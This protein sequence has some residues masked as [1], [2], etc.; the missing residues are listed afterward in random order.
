M[1]F[2]MTTTKAYRIGNLTL[3]DH[4]ESVQTLWGSFD[5]VKPEGR[6][7]RLEGLYASPSLKGLV[8]WVKGM[9]LVAARDE[10]ANLESSEITVANSETVFLYHV[11]TY[12]AV[13]GGRKTAADYWN[14]GIALSDWD[15]VSADRS[16]DADAWEILLPVE[17]I[18]SAHK[19]SNA[20]ILNQT[21]D[22]SAKLE[23]S[24][25]IQERKRFMM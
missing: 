9:H 22:E 15:T 3:A 5:E 18:K 17:T 8:R 23:L 25:M 4:A 11:P 13:L 14:T 12:D 2:L 19:I 10:D 16:L 20:R 1:L 7:G 6:T 24:R 21:A